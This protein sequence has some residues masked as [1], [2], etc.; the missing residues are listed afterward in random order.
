MIAKLYAIASNTFIETIRQP[1]FNLL[2]WLAIVWVSLVN[3]AL[4]TFSLTIG[5]DIKVMQDV[6]LATLLL[7]GL[8]GGV[9]S[10]NRRNYTRN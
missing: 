7:Y 5:N 8:L 3:P 6:G 2:T 1:V 4:A 10:A 9:F